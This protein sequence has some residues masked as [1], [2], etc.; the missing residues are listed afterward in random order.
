MLKYNV[1]GKANLTDPIM[2]Y[3][4]C[5]VQPA[6]CVKVL[7]VFIDSLLTFHDDISEETNN[8]LNHVIKQGLDSFAYQR[9]TMERISFRF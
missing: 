2:M 4:E 8:G 3:K 6:S 7:G 9:R 1:F 5:G